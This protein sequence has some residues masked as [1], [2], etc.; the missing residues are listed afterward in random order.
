MEG[1][2]V[3]LSRLDTSILLITGF[4]NDW[5]WKQHAQAVFRAGRI[6]SPSL[7]E[8]SDFSVF[9]QNLAK[10]KVL[11]CYFPELKRFKHQ[12]MQERNILSH[13][14]VFF[15]SSG[16]RLGSCQWHWPL[17]RPSAGWTSHKCSR[18]FAATRLLSCSTCS[19]D[20]QART[21]RFHRWTLIAGS[22][23]TILRFLQTEGIICHWFCNMARLQMKESSLL[24]WS[25][26]SSDGW[27]LGSFFQL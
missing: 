19:P 1:T 18:L 20:M 5:I 21:P 12:H 3:H 26:C 14:N 7:C 13:K 27:G 2:D 25:I 17:C 15:A 24:S 9:Q 6:V 10:S 22:P 8:R 11:L 23:G 4:R 16:L